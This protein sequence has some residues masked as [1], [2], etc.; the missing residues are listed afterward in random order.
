MWSFFVWGGH[1]HVNGI[2]SHGTVT[3]SSPK[4]QAHVPDVL[5]GQN[6]ETSVLGDTER[7]IQLD[8]V[9][10]WESKI[11]QIHH[12]PKAKEGVFLWLGSK[13]GGVSGN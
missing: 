8:K 12:S 6:T 4:I 2:Q 5:I 3:E 10:G 7:F 13:G 1:H 9:R 11:T